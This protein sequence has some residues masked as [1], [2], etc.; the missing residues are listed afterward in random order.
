MHFTTILRTHPP[1]VCVCFKASCIASYK[2]QMGT[3]PI[4]VM[5]LAMQLALNVGK[6]YRKTSQT[7]MLG[8]NT[9]TAIARAMS[10]LMRS[11]Y[12][13]CTIHIQ[14]KRCRYYLCPV[15]IRRRQ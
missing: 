14:Q 13:Y 2:V 1:S 7:Q 10:L 11:Y 8:V 5:L 3:E 15:P 4:L 12:F 9:G 6:H